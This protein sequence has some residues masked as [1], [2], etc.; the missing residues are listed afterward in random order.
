MPNHSEIWLCNRRKQDDFSGKNDLFFPVFL[1][2]NISGRDNFCCKCVEG[3]FVCPNQPGKQKVVV[4]S[5]VERGFEKVTHCAEVYDCCAFHKRTSRRRM[6]SFSECTS[7][8]NSHIEWDFEQAHFKQAEAESPLC[9]Q[10]RQAEIFLR[11]SSGRKDACVFAIK[12]ISHGQ[13]CVNEMIRPQGP[14]C[15]TNLAE[16]R[17][18]CTDQY[19]P[20]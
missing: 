9:I 14:K 17:P 4:L 15:P 3:S 11:P 8:L 19:F 2:E 12:A 10:V 7:F 16:E 18:A 5:C 6:M 13:E 1:E 20:D